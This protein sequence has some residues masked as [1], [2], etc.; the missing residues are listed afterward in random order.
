MPRKERYALV[1]KHMAEDPVF[2]KEYKAMK[3]AEGKRLRDAKLTPEEL[4]LRKF[5]REHPKEYEKQ[6]I[7]KKRAE[8]PEYNT[9]YLN[10]VH[11][12]RKRMKHKKWGWTPE[13][14]ELARNTQ[15]ERCAVCNEIAEL[16]PDHEHSV[17]PKPRQLLCKLCNTG[18]GMFRDDPKLLELAAS[19]LRKW[20]KS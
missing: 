8:D 11:A 2:E 4:E 13:A 3:K 19:Y 12:K 15:N 10:R 18:L 14:L 17:P 16:V 7:K 20:G 5:R 1:K 9:K 6:R